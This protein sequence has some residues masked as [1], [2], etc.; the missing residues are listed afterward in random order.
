[1]LQQSVHPGP[2]HPSLPRS[3]QGSPHAAEA[4]AS[5]GEQVCGSGANTQ[6]VEMRAPEARGVYS[7]FTVGA[8]PRAGQELGC[9]SLG[10]P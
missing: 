1:M 3:P 5:E 9:E 2:A 4:Q 6:R 7:K 8:T 10:K